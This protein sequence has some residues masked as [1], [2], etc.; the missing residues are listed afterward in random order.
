MIWYYTLGL[1][2][3]FQ[4]LVS[5]NSEK[6]SKIQV[7]GFILNLIKKSDKQLPVFTITVTVKE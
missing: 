7:I 3:S 2:I 1:I 6:D 4:K 5:E